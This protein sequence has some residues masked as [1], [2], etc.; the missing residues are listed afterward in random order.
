M[1]GACGDSAGSDPE[2][3]AAKDGLIEIFGAGEVERTDEYTTTE[4]GECPLDDAEDVASR[5]LAA[6]GADDSFGSYRQQMWV[7]ADE[8]R[9]FF[10]RFGGKQDKADLDLQAYDNEKQGFPKGDQDKRSEAHVSGGEL[11]YYCC[12]DGSLLIWRGQG[13]QLVVW[14]E[15]IPGDLDLETDGRKAIDAFMAAL[16]KPGQKTGAAKTQAEQGC[17]A[18]TAASEDYDRAAA[19]ASLRSSDGAREDARDLCGDELDDVESFAPL[20]TDGEIVLA[21]SQVLGR[22]TCD[23]RGIHATVELLDGRAT[24]GVVGVAD[25]EEIGRV[26]LKAAKEGDEFTIPAS[27]ASGTSCLVRLEFQI[28]L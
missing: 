18:L 27:V 16:T 6:V 13:M 9:G 22:P 12:E 23:R 15:A 1:I 21:G 14:G 2:A 20:D 26:L 7:T 4:I 3:N 28:P 10:C 5:V 8:V 11:T 19:V 24:L 25:G 17:E